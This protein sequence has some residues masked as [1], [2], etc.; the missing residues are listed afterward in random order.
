MSQS[1]KSYLTAN[2]ISPKKRL[3]VDTLSNF[4]ISNQQT[5]KEIKKNNIFSYDNL[6]GRSSGVDF[7]THIRGKIQKT[8]VY[9]DL[10]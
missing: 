3:N 9:I 2:I 10:I 4:L 6:V 1:Q 7:F 5:I 8:T